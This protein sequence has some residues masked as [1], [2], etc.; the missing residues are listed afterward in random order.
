LA[1]SD[2]FYGHILEMQ[3]LSRPD[4]DFRGSW[5]AIGK[6]QLHLIEDRNLKKVD[7]H[8]HHFAILVN[9]VFT[10]KDELKKKGLTNLQEHMRPDGAMQ[11]FLTD[12][13][14]YVVEFFSFSK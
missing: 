8:N 3:K 10:I 13:D 1:E 5:Y 12:P 9:D 6:Q 7:R 11:L 2:N 4:F 14:D